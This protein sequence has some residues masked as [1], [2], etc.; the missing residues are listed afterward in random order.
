M[1]LFSNSSSNEIKTTCNQVGKQIKRLK[2]SKLWLHNFTVEEAYQTKH[3]PLSRHQGG[4]NW[5]S[6]GGTENVGL[7]IL[8]LF[9]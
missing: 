8:E 4:F 7:S 6:P 2:S 5:I 1:I 9:H 3:I